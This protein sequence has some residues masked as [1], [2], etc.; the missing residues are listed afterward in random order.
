MVDILKEKYISNLKEA[1]GF[2]KGLPSVGQQL[3]YRVAM[4][5]GGDIWTGRLKLEED[6]LTF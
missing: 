5:A 1:E 3:D 6:L 4:K 2:P